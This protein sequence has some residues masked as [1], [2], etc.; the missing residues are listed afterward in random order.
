MGIQ[1]ERKGHT[2][3]FPFTLDELNVEDRGC[4]AFDEQLL[5]EYLEG[6]ID[7]YGRLCLCDKM[8]IFVE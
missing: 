8:Q 4:V 7:N 1:L 5:W 3:I 6:Q 2:H